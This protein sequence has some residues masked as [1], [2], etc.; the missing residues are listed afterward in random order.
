[1][2]CHNPNAHKPLKITVD[3]V[4]ASDMVSAPYK[5]LD[6]S[7][8]SDG[9]AAIVLAAPDEAPKQD[10]PHIAI[11]GSGAA[12]DWARLGEREYRYRFAGK[13]RS[14]RNA[15]RM[16]G[17]ENPREEIDIAEIYDAFTGA[18]LQG[19][20]ALGL[21]GQG[22]AGPATEAGHYD[23]DG[24]LPVNLSGGLIGQGGAPGAVGIAQAITIAQLLAGTYWP[25]LQPQGDLRRGVIDAHGGIAT[26]C[27]THV[28]ERLD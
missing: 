18:E 13:E 3:D 5:K 12:T 17:I 24:P 10:R 16:A 8:I 20:E 2:A 27:I 26:V 4:M 14:S 9:A 7:M 23:A 11:T 19:L 15:Y 22:E 28:L 6:C 25:R 1:N 21:A